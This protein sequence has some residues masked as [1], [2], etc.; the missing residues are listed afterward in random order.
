MMQFIELRLHGRGLPGTEAVVHR[1]FT[2]PATKAFDVLL[3]LV[4]FGEGELLLFD[5]AA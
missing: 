2:V 5:L 1:Q 3:F 4:E